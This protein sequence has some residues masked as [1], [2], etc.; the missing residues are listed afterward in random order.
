MSTTVYHVD[1]NVIIIV[2]DNSQLI[3]HQTDKFKDKKP[4]NLIATN[5]IVQRLNKEKL[6]VLLQISGCK[7][8]HSFQLSERIFDH[9][10]SKLIGIVIR[11]TR[12]LPKERA[13][14]QRWSVDHA[15]SRS[16]QSEYCAGLGEVLQGCRHAGGVW[17]ALHAGNSL[18]V[19][20]EERKDNYLED[21]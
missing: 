13:T 15:D 4:S 19:I 6:K 5:H 11:Y 20:Y 21:F 17:E 12:E 14:S 7:G 10:F 1:Q 2:D 3:H 8:S 9:I 18:H 16:L